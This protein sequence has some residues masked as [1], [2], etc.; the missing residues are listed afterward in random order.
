MLWI[1]E[2]EMVD[3][4][5]DLM[6]SSSIRG[7]QM[8]NF[9][10]LDARIASALN[11]IIHDSHFKK[12][13][14]SRG[15][16]GPRGRTFSFV[17]DRLL[18][19]IYEYFRVTGANDSVEN[20]ADLFTVGLR[21]D[22]IQE[23]DSKWD[24]ILLSMAKI[25]HDDIL[26][27]LYKVR[28]R[29]C[30]KLKTILELYDLEIH[31]K[32]LEPEYHRLK[33]V[34]KRSIEQEIRNKNFGSRNGNIEKNAVVKNPGT[35]QRVQR[36]LGDCWQWESNGQCVKGNNCSFRYGMNKRGRSSPSN[37]SPNSFM[38][39]NERKPSRTRSPRGK[40]PSGRMSRWPCKDYLKRN[41]HQFIL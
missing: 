11:K 21:N 15:T 37:P 32:K 4:E 1:K 3:S 14:Q 39:Q 24:G 41:L 17:E 28:I 26:E 25:P 34:V 33:A 20:Y 6:S 9:E 38:Q 2:V 12:K 13:N 10:V 36:I 5:D 22:D 18:G 7:I 29:E 30:D 40:S 27:G 16:K 19:L 23:F 35:K 8:P 31:Q